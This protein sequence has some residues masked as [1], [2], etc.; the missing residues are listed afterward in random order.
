MCKSYELIPTNNRKSFYGKA[1][2][3]VFADGSEVLQSYNT[4][5]LKKTA[6]GVFVRLWGGWSATTGTHIKSYCG[7]SKKEFEKLPMA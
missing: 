3:K 5:V 2:I 7:M 4:E 1:K 6:E